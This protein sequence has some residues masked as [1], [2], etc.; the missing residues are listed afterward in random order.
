ME[1][2]EAIGADG[3]LDPVH[4]HP[5]NID[6]EQ[7]EPPRH[8]PTAFGRHS[9][10]IIRRPAPAAKPH[11]DG[12]RQDGSTPGGRDEDSF[13]EKILQRLPRSIDTFRRPASAP[14]DQHSSLRS[15]RKYT[16][17]PSH[18][19]DR[20]YDGPFGRPSLAMTRR[21]SRSPTRPSRDAGTPHTPGEATGV[22]GVDGT[23]G[24]PAFQA[25]PPPLNYSLRTRKMAIFLF[26]TLLLVDSTAM[27]I[28]L[29]Y[30]L[31]YG[32]GPGTNTPTEKKQKLTP[33]AVFSIVTATV[34]GSSIIEYFLRLWR[35]WRKGSK[36]RVIGAHRWYFDWFHWNFTLG[37]VVIMVELIVGTIPKNPPIRLLSMP[38][39]TMLFV[40]GTE[41]LL[42]DICR[43]FHVPAPCRISS[44][45]K[46][47]QLRPGIYSLIE[48]VCAVDGSGGTDFRIALDRRYEASHVFR[49]M[50]RRLGL[51]W[52]IGA[53][54]CAVLCTTLIFT[55][56]DGEVAYVI[57]WSLPFVWVGIWT[58][59]TF[60]YV[61]SEL[62]R[63]ARAWSEEVAMGVTWAMSMVSV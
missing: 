17:R 59:A 56:S 55:L 51:F 13:D 44:I 5:S 49:A 28:G 21:S 10:Q 61:N 39:T 26:W 25:T 1:E 29:Y 3:P 4:P 41:L 12:Q 42:V 48:D 63:E 22:D 46:G 6:T 38:V 37:W 18:D 45:P 11:A 35:L 30:G 40:F 20:R 16:T 7:L 2:K 8:D 33:N 24:R 32:V 36:C 53:E 43:A 27:P 31:W 19:F 50:L 54:A 57:G 14:Q 62:K 23:S 60:W 9:L 58:L 47:A 52:A 34:G 15:P